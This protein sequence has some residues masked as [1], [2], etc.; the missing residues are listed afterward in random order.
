M[1]TP[2]VYK[3]IPF[4]SICSQTFDDREVEAAVRLLKNPDLMF[5]HRGEPSE[6]DSFEQEVCA[7]TGAG[8][9]LFVASGTCALS[10]CMA[11]L[12]IGPGDDVIIPAYTYIAT[13]AAVIDVGA[14]PILAEIDESLGL[15]PEDVERKITPYT[16]AIVAVHMQGCP[17]NLDAIRAVAKKHNL[18]MIEDCCQAIGAQ[19][20]GKYCGVESDAFA[21]SLNYF[22][23]ITCG[24]SGVFFAKDDRAFQMG[25]CQSDPANLMWKHG[26]ADTD[27]VKPF[28]RAGYR[29]NELA[30]AVARVQLSKLE[31][32]VAKT[33]SLKKHLISKLNTPIH[34]Q[35]QRVGDPDGDA[36]IS[37]AI[38]C[39]TPDDTRRMTEELAKEG[40]EVGSIYNAKGFPDRHIY[41]YWDSIMNLNAPTAAGYPWKDPAY[42]GE[43]K[44]SR[45]MCPKTLD[46]L[47]R[48]LRLSFN[49]GME[50]E[51]MDMIA[52]AINRADA[53][54]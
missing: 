29:A 43:V 16:K 53:R 34:Y 6:S 38:I 51:H 2:A 40:L 20:H 48:C 25:V 36:G 49:P 31:G 11:A 7:L 22:K 50:F 24:E 26:L 52:E 15:D 14:I 32:I 27:T 10:C 13:A 19:Y 17:C 23:T 37:F 35:L 39:N 8:H 3:P 33:R 18:Y 42:K 21:W 9:A 4:A 41:A 54:I 47:H 12:E 44:Y 46:I 28:T 5:R 1:S 30:A 45:D